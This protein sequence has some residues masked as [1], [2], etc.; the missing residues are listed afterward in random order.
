ME[1]FARILILSFLIS[2]AH[3]RFVQCNVH[4]PSCSCDFEN[5]TMSCTGFLSYENFPKG[6]PFVDFENVQFQEA[7]GIPECLL[8]YDKLKFITAMN[9]GRKLCDTIRHVAQLAQKAH[10]PI[11]LLTDCKYFS[12]TNGEMRNRNQIT[13]WCNVM[14]QNPSTPP[15]K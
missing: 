15:S 11:N 14:S 2:G 10:R 3:C 13:D 9:C 5:S 1:S 12:K 8:F 6:H 4:T 7:T